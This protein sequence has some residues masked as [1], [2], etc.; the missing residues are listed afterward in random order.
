MKDLSVNARMGVGCG[1]IQD[2]FVHCGVPFSRMQKR[3]MPH[4]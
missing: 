2:N 1:A 3:S 4:W